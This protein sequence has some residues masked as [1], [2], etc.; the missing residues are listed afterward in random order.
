MKLL[1]VLSRFPYPLEKGDKLRAYNQIRM[2][3]QHFDVYLFALTDKALRSSDIDALKV[4]CKEIH[5]EKINIWSKMANV[6][7]FWL[8]G[9]PI[10]CGYFFRKRAFRGLQSFVQKIQ[11]D[12]IYCQLVRTAEY[13]KSFPLNKT[14]D[15]QDVLSKGMFRRY[16]KAPF[17]AKP[18]FKL[19][20][21]RLL[22]YEAQ[23]FSCFNHHTIITTM[24]RDLMP[25]KE[26]EKIVIVRNGVDLSKFKY[27]AQLKEF[28]LIFTGNMAY[29]PNIDAAEYLVNQI[30][31]KIKTKFPRVS[32]VLCGAN[33]SM[34]V[35]A[36][37][38]PNVFVTGWV[39]SMTDYYAKSKIFIAP[40][41]L[42]TGL[43]NKLLE[44]MA[45][46]L[47]CITSALAGKPLVEVESNNA[48]M[49]CDTADEF[50]EAACKI[51]T[52]S[53]SYQQLALNGYRYVCD[54]YNWE[55]A[56][57]PLISILSE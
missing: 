53:E 4:F 50:A 40:M 28:D 35:L 15:Y 8:K 56:T 26:K 22:N 34:R 30:L 51:L 49:I 33:P 2:L 45:V 25:I 43:Q 57:Q 42:G 41:R 9:L 12:K 14:I 10:Q 31:P 19:E 18:F 48:V 3:S 32:L 11:P 46:Q 37:R 6:F 24:D 47:P 1:V 39:D 27:E 21:K 44:A 38:S 54:N 17:Y 23:S 36:L 29:A 5:T 13:V 7:S 52:D 55:G 20:Y 16:Q